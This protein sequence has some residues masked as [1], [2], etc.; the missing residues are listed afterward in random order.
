MFEELKYMERVPSAQAKQR[1]EHLDLVLG[2]LPEIPESQRGVRSKYIS[3]HAQSNVSTA[4]KSDLS[5]SKQEVNEVENKGEK[6]GEEEDYWE[7]QEKQ[8]AYLKLPV[9]R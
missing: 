6:E 8:L 3:S 1:E 5:G 7:W 2:K 4:D 9:F